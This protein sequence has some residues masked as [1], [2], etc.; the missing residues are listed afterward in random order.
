[1]ALTTLMSYT[2]SKPPYTLAFPVAGVSFLGPLLHLPLP[3]K[4]LNGKVTPLTEFLATAGQF[5]TR[6]WGFH[7]RDLGPALKA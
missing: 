7:C 6:F 5:S 1:M 4:Y 2:P 3:L